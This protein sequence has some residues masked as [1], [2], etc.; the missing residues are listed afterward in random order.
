MNG[1]RH[2]AINKL[3]V[4]YGYLHILHKDAMGNIKEPMALEVRDL[5]E[6]TMHKIDMWEKENVPL[7]RF[8]EGTV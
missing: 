2:D 5:C 8:I 7:K 3:S 4:I 6:D 1:W